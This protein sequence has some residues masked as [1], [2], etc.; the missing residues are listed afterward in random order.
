MRNVTGTAW[1]KSEIDVHALS[2]SIGSG[3]SRAIEASG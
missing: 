1:R 3:G 2:R